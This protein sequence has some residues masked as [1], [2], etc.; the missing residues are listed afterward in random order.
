ML[1][2][3]V[4]GYE[5]SAESESIADALDRSLAAQREGGFTDYAAVGTWINGKFVPAERSGEAYFVNK[6]LAPDRAGRQMSHYFDVDQYQD[7]MNT[8]KAAG[9]V[10]GS[11]KLV[12]P[13]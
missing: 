4:T 1:P 13:R 12:K 9:K 7:Q 3:T 8:L 2:P 6:G 5:T 11:R 10:T